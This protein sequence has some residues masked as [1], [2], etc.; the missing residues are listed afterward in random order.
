MTPDVRVLAE[1]GRERVLGLRTSTRRRIF[2]AE[3]SVH[4]LPQRT[5]DQAQAVGGVGSRAVMATTVAV[6]TAPLAGTSGWDWHLRRE[7][8]GRL[9]EQADDSS[10]DPEAPVL[11]VWTRPGPAEPEDSDA[12]WWA[13]A[14]SA[15]A[16]LAVQLHGMAVVTRW[17]W[18]MLPEGPE[19]RWQ[20]LRANQGRRRPKKPVAT[21]LPADAQPSGQV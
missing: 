19:R 5:L 1:F 4:R 8:V 3:L 15:C 20:R 13:A 11:M 12:A 21:A 7:L 10:S 17:G 14:R 16:D 18:W 2:P 6:W 9:L